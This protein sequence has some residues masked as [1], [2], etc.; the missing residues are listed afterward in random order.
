MSK[1]NSGLSDLFTNCCVL[2]P[3]LYNVFMS[4]FLA[5]A[6]SKILIRVIGIKYSFNGGFNDLSRL[7]SN[8]FAANK[9]I[10][11]LQYAGEIILCANS[12]E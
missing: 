7:K 9:F 2:N 11:E 1:T 8:L 10:S 4:V 5:I 12:T 3:Y 6:N